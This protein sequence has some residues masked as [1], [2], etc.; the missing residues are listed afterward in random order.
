MHEYAG[1]KLYERVIETV[2]KWGNPENIMFVVGATRADYVSAIRKI[3]PDHFMLVPG[4]GAQGGSL[5]DISHAG[6]NTDAGLLVNSSRGI[7]YA[8]SDEDFADAAV[9]EA[10]K[11][12]AEMAGYLTHINR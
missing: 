12:Q 5:S 4:V 3:I 6:L 8:S 2:C 1:M 11:L 10:Q 7:L 9:A